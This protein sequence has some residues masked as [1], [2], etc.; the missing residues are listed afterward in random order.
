[1][2]LEGE[3]PRAR[4]V[5]YSLVRLKSSPEIMREC[6]EWILIGPQDIPVVLLTT[7]NIANPIEHADHM[8]ERL[9]LQRIVFSKLLT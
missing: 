4:E 1:M 8:T 2:R 9:L 6:V 7:L 3:A 5:V